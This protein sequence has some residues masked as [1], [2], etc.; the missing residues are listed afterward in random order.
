LRAWESRAAPKAQ[1]Q[2]DSSAFGV[3]IALHHAP[4]RLE[5]QRKLEQLL[6]AP[7][8]RV[9]GQR[10]GHGIRPTSTSR[11]AR[12]TRNVRMRA[13]AILVILLVAWGERARMMALPDQTART[14]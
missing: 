10:P 11:G 9:V 4:W 14:C 2:I 12:G 6:H 3:D 8:R 7:D 5:L 13:R 1:A